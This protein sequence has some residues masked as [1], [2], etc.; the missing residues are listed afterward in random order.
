MNS[1]HTNTQ[2]FSFFSS[3]RLAVSVKHDLLLSIN[4]WK[5]SW[6]IVCPHFIDDNDDDDHDEISLDIWTA[7][8]GDHGV[9][10]CVCDSRDMSEV[11]DH[12]AGSFRMQTKGHLD[13]FITRRTNLVCLRKKRTDKAKANWNKFRIKSRDTDAMWCVLSYL[14]TANVEHNSFFT[15][16]LYAVNACGYLRSPS[17][18]SVFFQ[19]DYMT[20][21]QSLEGRKGTIDNFFYQYVHNS[22]D[23]DERFRVGPS[24]GRHLLCPISRALSSSRVSGILPH[25]GTALNFECRQW[26]D[27]FSD[28]N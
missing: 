6:V 26:S 8:T 17:M 11:A 1:T 12:S 7:T 18:C 24:P 28:S 19:V 21:L 15:F 2:I 22:F 16:L 14:R 25:Q 23:G 13:S 5:L 27:R 20:G 3:R 4:D 10:V 9:D